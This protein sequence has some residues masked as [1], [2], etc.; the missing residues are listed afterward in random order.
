MA[1]FSEKPY[2]SVR[3]QDKAMAKTWTGWNLSMRKFNFGKICYQV[4][5]FGWRV[6]SPF[7]PL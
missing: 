2:F 1:Y 6:R 5:M 7:V 3:F 4:Q